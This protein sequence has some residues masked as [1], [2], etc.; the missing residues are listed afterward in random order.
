MIKSLLLTTAVATAHDGGRP[1]AG[2]GV[3]FFEREGRLFLI[4]GRHIVGD[5]P[6]N[7]FPT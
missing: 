2:A 6:G 3:V 7:H 5:N 4:A 1:P